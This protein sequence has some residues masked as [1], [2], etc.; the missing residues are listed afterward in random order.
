MLA[1]NLLWL[2]AAQQPVYSPPP[3]LA[4]VAPVDSGVS[5]AVYD[6]GRHFAFA[7]FFDSPDEARLVRY[8]IVLTNE[9]TRHIVG[10][11]VRWI[12]TDHNGQSRA[13]TWS[14]D[15]FSSNQMVP[16]PVFPVGTQLIATPGGFAIGRP[17]HVSSFG[18]HGQMPTGIDDFD[19]AQRVTAVVDTIIFE[20]GRVIGTDESHLVDYI[21]AI[22]GAVKALVQ[23]V[24]DA[25]SDRRDVDD[26]LR[27]IVAMKRTRSAASLQA[28]PAGAWTMREA[29]LLL[30]F[31]VEQRMQRLSALEHVPPPP[32][33]YR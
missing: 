16:V 24:R 31:S 33:F 7:H 26:I 20:D 29:T 4:S 10:V 17:D 23:N 12:V 18:G 2:V 9:S 3:A 6:V 15:S 13:T 11:A 19:R 5:V 32:T 8:S 14:F 25:M 1:S 22:A 28:D 30:R 21:N 27:S